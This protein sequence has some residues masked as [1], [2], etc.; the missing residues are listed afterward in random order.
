MLNVRIM[1]AHLQRLYVQ[2]QK[3]QMLHPTINH[4]LKRIGLIIEI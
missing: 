4:G 3:K 1:I 2:S